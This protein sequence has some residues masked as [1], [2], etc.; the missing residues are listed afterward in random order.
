MRKLLNW[1]TTFI[2]RENT[3]DKIY[4]EINR[5]LKETTDQDNRQRKERNKK[6]KKIKTV[7]TYSQFYKKMKLKRIEKTIN[8]KDQI[9]S[10]SFEKIPERLDASRNF[11]PEDKK[12]CVWGDAG[13]VPYKFCNS[14]F[15][16][17]NCS[18]DFVMQGGNKLTSGRV[19]SDGGKLCTLRFYHHC[20]FWAPECS[21]EAAV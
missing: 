16:C 18:F 13:A 20:H 12:D 3:N 4:T 10:I 11:V 7:I 14:H 6:A 8:S 17:S 2:N 9:H 5:K 15:D 21:V 19:D 1:D